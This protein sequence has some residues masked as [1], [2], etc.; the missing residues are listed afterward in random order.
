MGT[1]TVE[2]RSHATR[3]SKNLGRL[4]TGGDG[5]TDISTDGRGSSH[6]ALVVWLTPAGPILKANVEVAASFDGHLGYPTFDYVT[7]HDCGRPRDRAVPQHRHV[8]LER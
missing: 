8:C 7:A 2:W 6:E 1:F 3:Q 4:C 5:P